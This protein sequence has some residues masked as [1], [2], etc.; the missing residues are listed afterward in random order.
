VV[1]EKEDELRGE[2][3]VE[4]ELHPRDCDLLKAG[5]PMRDGAGQVVV[6]DDEL[7]MPGRTSSSGHCATPQRRHLLPRFI[8]QQ[9]LHPHQALL[10]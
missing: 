9:I 6:R 2:V 5:F 7:L 3:G 1:L 8:E 10:H 4:A